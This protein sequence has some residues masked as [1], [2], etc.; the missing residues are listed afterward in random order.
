MTARL[1]LAFAGE[2]MFPRRHPLLLE[3]VGDLPV[4]HTPPHA[5]EPGTGT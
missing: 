3:S 5:H 4:P 1:R 2:T